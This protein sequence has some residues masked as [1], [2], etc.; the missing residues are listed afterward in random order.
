MCKDAQK[1]SK[2]FTLKYLTIPRA[3]TLGSSTYLVRARARELFLSF[4]NSHIKLNV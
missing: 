4:R 3:V 2:S 1:I